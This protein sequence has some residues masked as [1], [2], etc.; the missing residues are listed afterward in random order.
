[1]ERYSVLMDWKNTL[2]MSI[3]PKEIYRFNTIPIKIPIALF[4]ETEQTILKFVW[5]PKRP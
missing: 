2:K 4:T 5:K 1:M 3:L